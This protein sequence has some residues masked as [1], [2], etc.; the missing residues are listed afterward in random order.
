MCYLHAN[1]KS[2]QPVATIARVESEH[3]QDVLCLM[4]HIS[5]HCAGDDSTLFTA[6]EI[7]FTPSSPCDLHWLATISCIYS[8]LYKCTHCVQVYKLY[9]VG[10]K[11]G[12]HFTQHYPI[13]ILVK[14]LMQSVYRLYMDNRCVKCLPIQKLNFFCKIFLDPILNPIKV[15]G[16]DQC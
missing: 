7:H 9:M 5:S 2:I 4:L 15:G 1:P 16:S 13:H 3:S 11:G 14:Y 10:T 6:E 12:M 8:R